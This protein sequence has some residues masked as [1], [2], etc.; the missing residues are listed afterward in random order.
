MSK[1]PAK[2]SETRK[3]RK[4]SSAQS[5]PTKS[6]SSKS[7]TAKPMRARSKR[8]PIKNTTL[9]RV[10]DIDQLGELPEG[11]GD[12]FLVARDPHWLFAYWDFDYSS[13]PIPWQLQLR[14]FRENELEK[15]ISINDVARNWYIEVDH[16]DAEYRVVFEF[17]NETKQWI[18]IGKTLPTRTPP[19]AI[20]TRWDSEYATVPFHLSFNRLLE[21]INSAQSM[22]QPLTVALGRL[23]QSGSPEGAWARIKLLETLL[24]KNFLNRLSALDL[25][26]VSSFLAAH[27]SKPES[28]WSSELQKDGLFSV[29]NSSLSSIELQALLEKAGGLS[30]AEIANASSTSWGASGLSAFEAGISSSD[31]SWWTTTLGLNSETLSSLPFSSLP[32]L[33]LAGL[34]SLELSSRTL[35]SWSGLEFNLSSWSQLVSATSLSS[36]IGGISSGS[37]WMKESSEKAG[38][39]FFMHINAE[40]IFYG[41][42][43]P[44]AKVTVAGQPIHLEPDGTFRYHFK[45]PNGPFEVPIVATSP[46]GKETRSAVL[47]FQRS[48]ER[49]GDVGATG[50]PGFLEEPAAL[51]PR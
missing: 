36:E 9:P 26:E 3:G 25:S 18:E 15:T 37:S 48:T 38:R 19:E 43:D 20:S 49:H 32:P 51:F 10:S 46:D 44:Q 34:S 4:K 39:G 42:T 1:K 27:A 5:S 8:A 2:K 13:F 31:S 45:Y 23:Q 16:A 47:Y 14:I 33:E 12:I 17:L 28:G 7:S 6:S 22:G 29:G 41:G 24:G 11:Y 35:S 21:A 30:S 50:Q 40:V